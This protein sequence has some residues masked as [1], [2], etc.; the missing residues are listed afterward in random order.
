MAVC[1]R[2]RQAK[3]VIVLEDSPQVCIKDTRE[4]PQKRKWVNVKFTTQKY[5]LEPNPFIK[6]IGQ[7]T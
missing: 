6:K 7:L 4:T 5:A 2:K 1:T 3:E